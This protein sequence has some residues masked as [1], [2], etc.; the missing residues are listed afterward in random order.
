M[1]VT[2]N[3]PPCTPWPVLSR[4]LA[5]AGRGEPPRTRPLPRFP[6]PYR[7]SSSHPLQ[8]Y[9]SSS[10]PPPLMS[11]RV[12]SG[13]AAHLFLLPP[14]LIAQCNDCTMLSQHP[15]ITLFPY[16]R[17]SSAGRWRTWAGSAKHPSPH[18]HPAP[19]WQGRAPAPHL[20][21]HRTAHPADFPTS[22]KA[23]K[24][25]SRQIGEHP[26]DL[27][28]PARNVHTSSHPPRSPYP[29]VNYQTL[30]LPPRLCYNH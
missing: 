12:V 8:P 25:K 18:E 21:T 28:N 10:H 16:T 22:R 2:T 15:A 1:T 17:T 7:S 23:E 5:L 6:A 27:P 3:S 14:D 4:A 9:I 30:R 26:P 24:P 19:C 20:A 29:G 13:P 11:A